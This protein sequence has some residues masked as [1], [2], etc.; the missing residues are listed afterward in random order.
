MKKK[1]LRVVLVL[2]VVGASLLCIT[3]FVAAAEK[4]L[5]IATSTMG[6]S[7]YPIG[8]KLA[9]LWTRV[10]PEVSVTAQV[11]AG[12]VENVRLMAQDRAELGIIPSDMAYNA[13]NGRPPFVDKEKKPIRY[14]LALVCNLNASAVQ[15]ITLQ[16]AP[17]NS[18]RD[19][20]GK[21]V[22]VGAPGSS[23]EVR[24]RLI[25]SAYGL[26]YDQDVKPIFVGAEESAQVLK[27]QLADAIM[28]AAGI[29]T[30][31]V[32]NLA[33]FKPVKLIPM[34]QDVLTTFLKE[35]S[36]LMKFTIPKNTYKGMDYNCVTVASTGQLYAS[37][38]LGA[39]TVYK[40]TK[41]MFENVK[42]V[43]AAHGSMKDWDKEFALGLRMTK[44]HPGA[45]KY[46]KEAGLIK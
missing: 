18:V 3:Q 6:G 32:M 13:V 2:A 27:D 21:R 19:L 36:Y 10:V 37:P 23:V 35:H 31:A 38:K 17:I 29:P 41:A 7:F 20:K 14:D 39:E 26:K 11:T 4:Q 5:V 34:E 8:G 15:I 28:L 33:T 16:D 22:A 44:F 42:E 43:Q 1:S 24:S 45:E 25:L 30:A 9:G 46:Y 40:M 12:G